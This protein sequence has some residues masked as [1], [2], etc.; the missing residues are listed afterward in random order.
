MA[1]T[2]IQ[3]NAFPTS[4]DLSNVDLTLGA[5]EVLTANIADAN[6]TT[7]KI[8]DSAVETSKIADGHVTHA[9]LHTDMD[10]SSKTVTLPTLTSNVNIDV[11]DLFVK[12]TTGGALGQVQIG[13]GTVQGF[14]NIQ[15]GDGTRTVQVSS[16]GDT[17]FNGG[18]VGIGTTSPTTKL[19]ITGDVNTTPL[20]LS[21]PSTSGFNPNDGLKF[22]FYDPRSGGYVMSTI[23]THYNGDGTHRLSLGADTAEEQLVLR[24]GKVGIGITNPSSPLH[25]KT[26]TNSIINIENSTNTGTMGLQWID[27]N[28]VNQTAFYYSMGP[29]KQFLELNG[30]GLQIYSKQ[31]SS[32]I[33]EF[34]AAAGGY[35]NV[36][37]PNG[38]LTVGSSLVRTEVID[39][40]ALWRTSEHYGTIS[41]NSDGGGIAYTFIDQ[42]VKV[43]NNVGGH[44][45]V[46]GKV[47]IP[48]GTYRIELTYRATNQ[49]HSWNIYGSK[50]NEFTASL[51]SNAAYGSR[52]T[53][54]Q[55]TGTLESST[56]YSQVFISSTAD[57]SAGTYMIEMGCNP[58]TGGGYQHYVE[59]IKLM[60]VK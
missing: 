47:N 25:L 20:R 23:R 37:I 38:T 49:Q 58:Y 19:D 57:L 26:T 59:S 9:K 53:Y 8:A 17:Y 60:Q 16:D 46:V 24:G 44:S 40:M 30:N 6:V 15:K 36:S 55:I 34:G 5:G 7:A 4:I 29:N 45:F 32:A 13:A 2:K 51:V 48:A 10:L 56:D 54:L 41:H 21:I 42:I 43:T 12:D 39:L 31:T 52:T 22:Q 11:A 18:N 33:A 27:E 50:G 28:A 35:N 3:S 1:I 14:I